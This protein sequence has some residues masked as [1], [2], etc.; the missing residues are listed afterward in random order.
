MTGVETIARI[1]FEHF[2]NGK[3][4]PAGCESHA[5]LASHEW[6]QPTVAVCH[7]R[8]ASENVACTQRL[9]ERLRMADIVEE[10]R[11][12]QSFPALERW[13]RLK[14]G[15]F[16][17]LVQ[18]AAMRRPRLR[19]P[20]WVSGGPGVL[21]SVRLRRAGIRLLPRLDP[22]GAGERSLS[23]APLAPKFISRADPA[24][25]WT[26]AHQGHAFFAYA[27]NYLIDTTTALLSTSKR[28][29]LSV[30]PRLG[31]RS[32]CSSGRK[33]ALA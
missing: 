16:W 14:G 26:G 29:G 5:V 22:S 21:D 13:T 4:R 12:N 6:A 19:V 24:A 9:R 15:R 23:R 11:G 27:V 32:R 33:P 7:T 30:R 31:R 25:Q 20:Q 1:R 17:R 3:P 18:A 28:R 2:Q 10:V 8:N